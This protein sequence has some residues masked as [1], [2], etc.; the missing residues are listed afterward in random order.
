MGFG[1]AS[2]LLGLTRRFSAIA[3]AGMLPDGLRLD[4]MAAGGVTRAVTVSRG[5][6][7]ARVRA[8][9]GSLVVARVWLLA[10]GARVIAVLVPD[11]GVAEL[12][13][14]G[15]WVWGRVEA[16]EAFGFASAPGLMKRVEL[17]ADAEWARVYGPVAEG[18]WLGLLRE[19]AYREL[20]APLAVDWIE[21]LR[22]WVEPGIEL[23][24]A[25][26]LSGVY[27]PELMLAL[28][29]HLPVGGVFVDVGANAGVFTLFA[30]GRVGGSGRVIAFEP[31]AR[32]FGQLQRNVG[33]NGFGQVELH[34]AAVAEVEGS[35]TLSVAEDGHA[36]HNT[37]GSRF[38]AA[39]TGRVRTEEVPAVRLDDVLAGLE[40]CDAIKLDIEGAELLALR[41]AVGVLKRL[42]PVLAIEING[43]SLEACGT[44]AAEVMGFLAAQGYAAHDIDPATG[45]LL[46]GCAVEPGIS[47]NIMALPR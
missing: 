23:F 24:R 12:R 11:S 1:I 21:G 3:A 36:G 47:K 43:A 45:A 29:R 38:A 35:L 26:V 14:G 8:E 18:D 9:A 46:A 32:E 19:R 5:G 22:L 40:R 16:V 37:I 34:R 13:P 15:L 41:G 31:S 4:I 30:A 33:L 28:G 27:E 17:A 2:R 42:R 10:G 44:G 20:R 39:G 25:I 6:G 7:L